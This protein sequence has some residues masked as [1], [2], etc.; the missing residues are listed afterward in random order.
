MERTKKILYVCNRVF[1]PP[2]GGHEVEMYHY[3]RGLCEKRG[4]TIDTYIFEE[5]GKIDLSLK[6]KFINKVFCSVP[7]SKIE[8]GFNLIFKTIFSLEPFPIQCSLYYSK[9]NRTKLRNV[10][11]NGYDAIFVDMIRLA[12]YIDSFD[13]G[14]EKKILDIDDMLSKRY[15]RQ[16]E[17]VDKKTNI[18]GRYVDRLPM[19]VKKTLS[20]SWIKNMILKIESAKMEKAEKL[21]SSLYD[22]VV[23]V[24]DIET[25]EFNKDN[26][27]DKAVTLTMGVDYKYFSEDVYIEKEMDVAAFVANMKTSANADSVRVI[28]NDILPHSRRIKKIRLIGEYSEELKSEFI[29]NEKVEFTGRVDDIR[30]HVKRAGLFLAPLA[31]GTGIKT[32]ILE[33]MAMGVP[34]VTNTIGA[35]GIPGKNGDH[36]LVSDNYVELGEFIDYC[37]DHPKEASRIGKKAQQLIEKYYQWDN[38]YEQ[39]SKLGL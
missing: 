22:S 30:I 24:S 13:G 23:F 36:W 21:Y 28:A 34:V 37:I 27:F 10:S 7:I 9:K 29:D 6:P 15:R 33:A 38:L 1:W 16:L 3:C 4:Y 32:K 35:E 31:Y 2:L 26:G 14:I 11:S 17:S 19:F 18:A 5:E 8:I 20:V 12:P 39:F 25:Q